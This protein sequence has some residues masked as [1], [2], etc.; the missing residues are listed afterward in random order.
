MLDEGLSEWKRNSSPERL[1][2]SKASL[3]PELSTGG[4]KWRTPVV[5]PFRA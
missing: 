1:L 4:S 2:A 5:S 3:H